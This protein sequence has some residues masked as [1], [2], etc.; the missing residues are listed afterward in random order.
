M[1][2][3]PSG[4][5]LPIPLSPPSGRVRAA[6]PAALTFAATVTW[7]FRGCEGRPVRE[8]VVRLLTTAWFCGVYA[9][10]RFH[11][12]VMRSDSSGTGDRDGSIRGPSSKRP[13]RFG[14]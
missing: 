10:H 11:L 6:N 4:R 1:P 8:F 12:P 7:D 9:S 5:W 3:T 2:R 14:L 13:H